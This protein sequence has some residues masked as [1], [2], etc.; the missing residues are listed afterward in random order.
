M[1]ICKTTLTTEPE[2]KTSVHRGTP[3]NGQEDTHQAGDAMFENG[4]WVWC[5]DGGGLMF[6]KYGI[7]AGLILKF[8][9]ENPVLDEMFAMENK[10]VS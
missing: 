8:L 6:D 3:Q 9:N 7:G 10:P 5:E 1:S 2:R 4:V